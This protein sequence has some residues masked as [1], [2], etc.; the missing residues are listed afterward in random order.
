MNPKRN[1]NLEL[2]ILKSGKKKYEL[3][4]ALDWPP[5]KLSCIIHG[6]QKPTSEDQERLSAV[7]QADVAY[8]FPSPTDPVAA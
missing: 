3:A 1:L 5:S 6:I 8:L 2:E 4:R 7:L